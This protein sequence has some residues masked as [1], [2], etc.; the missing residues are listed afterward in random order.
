MQRLESAADSRG[1]P[2]TLEVARQILEDELPV[3]SPRQQRRGSGLLAPGTGALRSGE[4]MIETWPDIA[5][6]L[7]EDWD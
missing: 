2:L 4:K 6:R 3:P 7:I 1:V 5:E